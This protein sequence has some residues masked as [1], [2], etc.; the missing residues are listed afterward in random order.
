MIPGALARRYARAL[1]ELA[2]EKGLEDKVLQE[3]GSFA[4]IYSGSEELKATL[5][6]T[7]VPGEARLRILDEILRRIMASDLTKK[8]LRLLDAKGRMIGVEDIHRSYKR[9]VDD[10]LGRVDAE[11]ITPAPLGMAESAT[12]KQRLEKITR[13]QVVL[14]QTV[15]K[16]M[17]GGI[18]TRVGHLVYDGSVASFLEEARQA[19]MRQTP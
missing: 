18:V 14:T 4:E 5:T 13:R 16:S 10:K 3:L 11:V 7:M 1:L 17:I 6:S 2:S 19:L 15:D 9:M 12:L 8:F